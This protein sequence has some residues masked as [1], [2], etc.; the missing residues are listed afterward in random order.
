MGVNKQV[1]ETLKRQFCI[2]GFPT[3]EYKTVQNSQEN[4]CRANVWRRV[5]GVLWGRHVSCTLREGAQ[6]CVSQTVD[7]TNRETCE[8]N[9]V[10][11][12]MGMKKTDQRRMEEMRRLKWRKVLRSML[13]LFCFQL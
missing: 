11:R 12:I 5:E 10:R 7:G 4:K 3:Q 8:N 6:S 2:P 9:R 1:E 13:V